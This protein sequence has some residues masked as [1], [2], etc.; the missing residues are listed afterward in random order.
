MSAHA[1]KRAVCEVPC[2]RAVA[3]VELHVPSE[4]PS[5]CHGACPG[6]TAI[7]GTRIGAPSESPLAA[8]CQCQC[9]RWLRPMRQ[10]ASAAAALKLG[11]AASGHSTPMPK[12]RLSKL[13]AP[14]GP[15]RPPSGCAHPA[16]G[17]IRGHAPVGCLAVGLPVPKLRLGVEAGWDSELM[18]VL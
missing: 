8:S 7:S 5:C 18:V 9:R 10:G 4:R 1:K 11:A 2:T 12:G 16:A 13:A 3:K 6:R 14:A 17:G 15:A